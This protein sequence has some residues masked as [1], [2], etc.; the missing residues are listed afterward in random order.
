MEYARCINESA[1]PYTYCIHCQALKLPQT[2]HDFSCAKFK[3]RKDWA[4]KAA[5][6]IYD[7]HT[8]IQEKEADCA[9]MAQ[10][11]R[12]EAEKAGVK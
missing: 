12:E 9:E 11:I 8:P 1:F 2:W 4:E 7:D 3:R 6:R 10:F 5:E